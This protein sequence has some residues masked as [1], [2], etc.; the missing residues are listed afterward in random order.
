[1]QQHPNYFPDR[2]SGQQV[3]D[4]INDNKHNAAAQKQIAQTL[5]KPLRCI[6]A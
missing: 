1:M 3:H 5:T 2:I 6:D 4:K